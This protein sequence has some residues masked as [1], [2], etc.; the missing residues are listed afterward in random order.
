MVGGNKLIFYPLV[1]YVRKNFQWFITSQDEC[2]TIDK[3]GLEKFLKHG[4]DSELGWIRHPGTSKEK[5]HYKIN[6]RGARMNPQ[7]ENLSISISS[8]GDSFC[9]C[10][11]N[12]DNETWQWHLSELTKSNVQ[13]FGVGNYGLDQALL[14]L[15]REYTRNKTK[16]VI[17]TIVPST[18]VRILCIWKHYNEYGNTFGFKPRFK[19]IDNKV[20]KIENIIDTKE[21]FNELEKYLPFIQEH[22]YFYKTKFKREIVKFPYIYYIL[23]NWRRNLPLICYV[24]R[25]NKKKAM[26]IIQNINLKLRVNL[27]KKPEAIMLFQVI[28][29]MFVNYAKTNNFKPILL[30]IPQKDDVCYIKKHRNYYS[31]ILRVLESDLEIIDMYKKFRYEKLDCIYSDDSKY[32]GHPNNK[33]NKIISLEVFKKL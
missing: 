9:F 1:R 31:D 12:K 8:Y 20:K 5:E 27:F 29:K 24:L 18:I 2:P 25:K 15:K 17:M 7:H 19:V 3:V 22:D 14:R 16:V 6:K 30:V 21:K 33:G 26:A 23:K 10:R 13:N 32:G 4:Y 11:Q 28:V